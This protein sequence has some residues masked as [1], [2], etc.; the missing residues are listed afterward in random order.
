MT[1]NEVIKLLREENERMAKELTLL[2]SVLAEYEE[3]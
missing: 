1:D 3:E 2:R